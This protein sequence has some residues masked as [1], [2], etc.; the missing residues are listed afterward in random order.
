ME[1]Q[2]H[3]SP[4]LYVSEVGIKVK[5]LQKS[6]E[7]YQDVIG[8]KVLEQTKSKASLTADGKTSILS[9]EQPVIP[10][11]KQ[12]RTAG[13]F[14]LAILLPDR[15]ALSQFLRHV[16]EIGYPMGAGDHLVSEA[17][18][19]E[20]IDGNGIEV[21]HDR[22]SKEW[23]WNGDLVKMDTLQVDV[24]SVYAESNKP[25][26]GLPAGTVMGHIHLHVSH[27]DEAVDF[28]TK[29][30]GFDIVSHYPQAVFLS[31]GKYHHHIAVNTWA[32]VGAPPTP[33]NGVGLNWFTVVFPNEAKRE[34]TINSLKELGASV[35]K[36]EDYYVTADPSGN[37]IRL[38][39]E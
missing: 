19:L 16:Y 1:K 35:D 10:L 28:Y 17:F 29:G 3:Q 34:E 26:S 24:N 37:K 36:E 25:W 9:L 2:F 5:D 23:E 32:G 21:Y 8:L 27:L 20:D 11:P 38:I 22:P 31:T 14:H 33:K 13:L 18:Y 6:V 4:N 12:G 39:L 15:A 7:F 30:L